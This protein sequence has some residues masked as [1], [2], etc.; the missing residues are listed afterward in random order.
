MKS[1]TTELKNKDEFDTFRSAFYKFKANNA[2]ALAQLTDQ[3]SAKRLD[4]LKDVLMTHR[5]VVKGGQVRIRKILVP[6]DIKDPVHF[7]DWN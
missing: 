2:D 7:I 6:Q 3:L 1:L 4:Y 5:V